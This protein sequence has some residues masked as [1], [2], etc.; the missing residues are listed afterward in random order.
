[1]KVSTMWMGARS[2]LMLA[3]ASG[4]TAVAL[5]GCDNGP[6]SSGTSTRSSSSTTGTSR[7]ATSTTGAPSTSSPN[8]DN[9][10][11]N[12]TDRDSS[13]P[14]PLDQGMSAEDTRITADIRKAILADSSMSMNAQNC[15][16]I[17]N[18]GVV[19]L[20]GPVASETEKSAIESKAK[21][22]AGVT[23][24]DNQLEVKS[25]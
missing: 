8:A 25:K 10:S 16:V 15:K 18:K 23:S 20:R 12:K 17:T 13:A 6:S 24:V 11:R 21:S 3:M 9:T 1:M 22:V 4:V 14:T 7:P 19:T 2:A 5:T